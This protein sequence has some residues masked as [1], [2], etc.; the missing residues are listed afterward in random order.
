MAGSPNSAELQTKQDEES[1]ILFEDDSDVYELIIS[2]NDLTSLNASS[3]IEDTSTLVP[4]YEITAADLLSDDDLFGPSVTKI[5]S[6]IN[7]EW[8]TALSAG[9]DFDFDLAFS[10]HELLNLTGDNTV[11]D[12]S[13]NNSL[14]LSREGSQDITTG[15]KTANIFIDSGSSAHISGELSKV[16][17]YLNE[18]NLNTVQLEGHFEGIE[19]NLYVENPDQIPEI[20]FDGD[21]LILKGTQ[22]KK[23]TFQTLKQCWTE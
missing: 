10:S 16:N 15:S 8:I 18:D 19:F 3:H 1:F 13:T 20:D 9:T 7:E 23:L 12:T 4:T 5:R 17:L 14:I 2:E 11:Y 6:E 21:R 22:H